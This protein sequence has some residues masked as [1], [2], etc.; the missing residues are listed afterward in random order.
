LKFCFRAYE[1]ALNRRDNDTLLK[2][3]CIPYVILGG[4]KTFVQSEADLDESLEQSYLRQRTLGIAKITIT[5]K[6]CRDPSASCPIVDASQL[7]HAADGKLIEM[8]ETVYVLREFDDGYRFA[9][10]VVAGRD[11]WRPPKE[12]SAYG[13]KPPTSELSP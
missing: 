3:H 9:A 7:R 13:T 8:S 10:S 11:T 2:L 12:W 4:W 1:E 5:L 6:G